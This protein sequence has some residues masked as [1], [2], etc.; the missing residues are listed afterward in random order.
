MS[1]PSGGGCLDVVVGLLMSVVALFSIGGDAAVPVPQPEEELFPAIVM[2][3][4]PAE[5]EYSA[6]ELAL[7]ADIVGTRLDALGLL[8]E[9]EVVD[10]D[11]IQVVLGA[12]ASVQDVSEAITGVGYLELVNFSSIDERTLLDAFVGQ[13]IITTGQVDTFGEPLAADA[14]PNPDTGEPFVTVLTNDGLASAAALEDEFGNW[15][16][17]FEFTEVGGAVM[18]DYTEAN[19]GEPLAIVLEGEVL[20]IPTIQARLDTAGVITGDFTEE[21]VRTLA[22][23][24]QSQPLPFP[25][26]IASV[27]TIGA[28]E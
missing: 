6:D 3:L 4:V 20:S 13:A 19:I 5:D 14:I 7:A 22:A 1:E 27:T 12:D 26:E 24:L 21:E 2:E 10:G 25:L 16:V 17:E 9:V 23:Q 15:I 11:T 18:G 8:R 28:P